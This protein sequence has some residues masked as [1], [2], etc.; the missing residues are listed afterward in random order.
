MYVHIIHLLLLFYDMSVIYG[1]SI[2]TYGAVNEYALNVPAV[3]VK[4]M[5]SALHRIFIIV[6]Y[7]YFLV[8]CFFLFNFNT[9]YSNHSVIMCAC[10]CSQHS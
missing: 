9:C 3:Y 7:L 10:V 2:V 5:R 4:D 6:M 8:V 1:Y